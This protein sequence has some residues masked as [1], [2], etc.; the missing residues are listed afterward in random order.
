MLFRKALRRDLLNLAGIVFSTLFV[1]LLTT[2]LIRLL[3]RAAGGRVD[4][5][6]V[7]PL[8]AFNA[9]HVLPVL[10]VLTLYISVLMALTRAYRDSEMVVWFASGQSLLA[11]IRPVM[12]FAAPFVVAIALIAFL[13]AP[14]ANREAAEYHQR[15][16]QREDV[17]QVTA[18][19][20]RES[21]SANRVFFVESIDEVE[22]QVRNV[23]VTQRQGDSVV[24]V[25]SRGGQIEV[26]PNGDRFLV[27]DDG[28]RYDGS[29]GALDFRLMEFD[30]YGIRLQPRAT[31]LSD[32][33][34]RIKSTVALLADPDPRNQAELLWRIGLPVSAILVALLAI[35]LSAMNPRIGR[36]VNLL[37]A[38]LLYVLYNNLMSVMQAWVAQERIGFG[39]AVWIVHAALAALIVL[40]FWRRVHLP[41]RALLAR[42]TLRRPTA[43]PPV[44]A[45]S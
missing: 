26:Q 43:R 42:F 19:Q 41:R 44:A 33:R 6:A 23:F 20:F 25:V 14:W 4:T 9:I 32:E 22:N 29:P 12:G 31:V 18:G 30:R 34:S 10:L 13:V 3:G 17:S 35:P 11:W 40:L 24:V 38:L 1:I 37:A 36:S 7:L 16:A 45:R 15:F 8:I 2:S 39:I 27:L 5:A 28:R 21:V